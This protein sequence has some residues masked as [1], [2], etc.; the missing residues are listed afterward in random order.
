MTKPARRRKVATQ[1]QQP[2]QDVDGNLMQGEDGEVYKHWWTA[3]DDRILDTVLT[4]ARDL[5]QRSRARREMCRFYSECYG[6][7][8]LLGIGLTSYD[9]AHRGFVAPSLPY[10]VVRRAVNT[11]LAKITKHKPL[12][13]VLTERGDY[14]QTKRALKLSNFTAGAFD[15]LKAFV[16]GRTT[17][18]DALTL[19]T[20]LLKVWHIKGDEL[21]RLDRLLPWEVYVDAADGRMGAPRQ[22]FISQWRDKGEVRLQYPKSAS[23][24]DACQSGSSLIDDNPDYADQADLVLVTEAYRLPVGKGAKMVPGRKTVVIDNAL[25]EDEEYKKPYFPVVP[26]QYAEAMLGAWGEGLAAEVAGFQYEINYVVETLRMAHRVVG[27]GIWMVPDGSGIPDGQFENG[28]GLILKHKMGLAPTYVSPTPA[29]PQSYEYLDRMTRGALEWGA[30]I[31]QLSANGQKPAGIDSGKALQTIQDVEDDGLSV[32]EDAYEQFYVDL[33]D[34]VIDECRD[35]ANENGGELRVMSP[36]KRSVMWI[37]WR[38]VDMDRD[39]IVMQVWPTN[40][41]GRTPAA[42]LQMV[43]DL[44]NGGIIDRALYLKLLDAPDIDSETDLAGAMQEVADSQIETILDLDVPENDNRTSVKARKKAYEKARPDPYQDLVYAMHRAQQHIC[45]GRLR[46]VPDEILD[47][48]RTY[49]EDCKTELDKPAEE[50]RKQ[51]SAQAVAQQAA[52]AAGATPQLAP[53]PIA[54][55]GMAPAHPAPMQPPPGGPGG[56]SPGPPMGQAA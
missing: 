33:A 36:Q 41:L 21:P 6:T 44:F 50:A 23:E 53:A 1:Y 37:D 49:I 40:L 26:L 19:G 20:G 42:R 55:P 7:Q 22:L 9:P 28:T 43:N 12:P 8:E 51:A 56:P 48:L 45:F 11:V 4:R 39:R 15:A 54:P 31:S 30:G 32:F 13:M 24:I 3:S 46:G 29:N 27:T 2:N 34:H 17:A 14:K 16:K 52:M 5:R 18:R 47:M 25:L 10:N 35:I 38:D